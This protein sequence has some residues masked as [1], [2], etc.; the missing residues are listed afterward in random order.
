MKDTVDVGYYRHFKGN[1]YKVL[2]VAKHTET[3]EMMVIYQAM[4]GERTIW[5]RPLK[6]FISKVDKTKYP[7]C[8]QEYRFERANDIYNSVINTYKETIRF[9]NWCY[10]CQNGNHLMRYDKPCDECLSKTINYGE[11]PICFKENNK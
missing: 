9:A 11:Q 10:K 1:F 5:C 3:E 6:D 4:Y 2:M 7:D 8:K